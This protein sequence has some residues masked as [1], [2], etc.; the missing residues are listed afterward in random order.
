VN[1]ARTQENKKIYIISS[2]ADYLI[3]VNYEFSVSYIA[4]E[5]RFN[6]LYIKYV[7]S[8]RIY[9]AQNE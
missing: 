6:G 8:N 3:R 5:N 2:L 4:K 1:V 7:R 9:Y